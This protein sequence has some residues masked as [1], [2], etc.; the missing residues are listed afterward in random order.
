MY[1]GIFRY[2]RYSK[3]RRWGLAFCV[4][5]WV[6][7]PKPHDQFIFPYVC[8]TP[9]T[10]Q[11]KEFNNVDDIY[12]EVE[13]ISN[14]SDGKRTIGQEMWFLVPLFANPQYLIRDEFY[15][16]IN[17]YHYIQDYNIPL[18]RTLDETDA[19]K[20]EYFTIIRNEMA[21]ALRLKQEKDIK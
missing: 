10:R 15:N 7:K 21:N 12:S 18:G 9:I 19:N 2:L 6:F 11:K 17:E 14:A 13:E 3:K 16:L 4:W 1:D 20:L 8:E 5:Y